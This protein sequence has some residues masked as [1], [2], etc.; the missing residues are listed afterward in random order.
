MP[1]N[2][3]KEFVNMDIHDGQDV[4]LKHKKITTGGNLFGAL[5]Y[6]SL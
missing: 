4:G 6:Y 2:T 3:G 5:K 1:I